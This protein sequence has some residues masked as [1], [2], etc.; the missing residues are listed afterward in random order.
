MEEQYIKATSRLLKWIEKSPTAFQA[1]SVSADLL[2]AQG[3]KE[4]QEGAEWTLCP[5]GSYFVRRNG[6]SILAF[7]MPQDTPTGF[8]ISASHTD[9]PTF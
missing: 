1:V 5:Q 6:S 2:L 4:L 9:S 3:F 7:R 8:M